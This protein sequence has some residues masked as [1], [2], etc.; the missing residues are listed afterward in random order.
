MGLAFSVAFIVGPLCGAWFAKTSDIT[1]GPWGE[2][3]ALYALF[4]S[5]AN[6]ALVAFCLP[7]TLA[8]VC[9]LIIII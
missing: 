9:S 3:P 1:N 7:E 6:I 8:K 4:L 2:R 5:I